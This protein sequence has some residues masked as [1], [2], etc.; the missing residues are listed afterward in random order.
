MKVNLFNTALTIN[1]LPIG[2]RV[3]AFNIYLHPENN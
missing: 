3:E 2:C 1:G